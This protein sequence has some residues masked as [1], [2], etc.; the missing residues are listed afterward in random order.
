M[1]NDMNVQDDTDGWVL[2]PSKDHE[3]WGKRDKHIKNASLPEE[4]WRC[5]CE[6][7]YQQ[8]EGDMVIARTVL[9]ICPLC[10]Y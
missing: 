3:L 4:L 9:I 2:V 10:I 8:K 6:C 5:R 1:V 7:G